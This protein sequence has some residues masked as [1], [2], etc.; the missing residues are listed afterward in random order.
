MGRRVTLSSWMV[1]VAAW[2]SRYPGGR[3]LAQAPHPVAA[4]PA[5]SAESSGR[6]TS[7]PPRLSQLMLAQAETER[8]GGD[9]RGDE[10]PAAS[11]DPGE[12]RPHP[13]P[14][15]HLLSTYGRGQAQARPPQGWCRLPEL[16]QRD[17]PDDGGQHLLGQL[18]GDQ[19]LRARQQP[20]GQHRQRQRLHVVR[21][22]EVTAVQRGL[23][24]GWRAAG[25]GWPA[26][27]L[28]AGAPGGARRRDQA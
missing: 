3:D 23:A 18:A 4:R 5:A 19:R 25:A 8:T 22:H 20:V 6:K 14:S 7:T 17:L 27:M 21:D 26:A 11:G 2:L 9:A 10:S 24:P 13:A 28:P 1:T 16:G 12:Q 15:F